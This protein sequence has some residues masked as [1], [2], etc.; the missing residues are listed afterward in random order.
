MNVLAVVP[1]HNEEACLKETIRTLTKTCPDISYLIVNDGSTDR[2]EQICLDNKFDYVTLPINTRLTSAFRTGMKYAL[3]HDFDV[4]V[5]FDADGQHLPEYIPLMLS[6]LQQHKAD[7]VIAS[8]CC[9]GEKLHGPRGVGSR[10]ISKL[11][12]LTTGQVITDPTSGMRMYNRSVIKL[13]AKGFDIAPE[14]DTIALLARKGFSIIEIPATM[15]ERQGGESYLDFT[16]VIS[17]MLRTLASIL[18]F[19]WFR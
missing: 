10:L 18:L 15:Q 8:R 2:T 3:R 12:R 6:A 4:V 16:H 5:Q 11:I 9:N 17:Y 7:V 13:F 14:P 1:A 19:Q